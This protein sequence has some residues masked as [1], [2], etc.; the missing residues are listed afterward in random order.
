MISSY[1]LLQNVDLDHTRDHIMR[2]ISTASIARSSR[3]AMQE[4]LA[5]GSCLAL[6]MPVKP[7]PS[8][9]RFTIVL[10]WENYHDREDFELSIDN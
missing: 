7:E 4:L 9:S 3:R 2:Q 6:G 5:K 1:F 8:N 10:L